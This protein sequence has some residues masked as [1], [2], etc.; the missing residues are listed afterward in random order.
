[1]LFQY[2][3]A[4]VIFFVMLFVLLL[5]FGYAFCYA[6][7]YVIHSDDF[8]IISMFTVEPVDVIYRNV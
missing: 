2:F 8:Y 5:C 6:F 4:F 7:C 3:V 1:M